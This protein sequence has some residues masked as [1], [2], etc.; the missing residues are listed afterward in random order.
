MLEV[1]RAESFRHREMDED[2]RVVVAALIAPGHLVQVGRPP[3][4]RSDPREG[5][6]Q[7]AGTPG[8]AAAVLA[9]DRTGRGPVA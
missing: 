9:A 1:L 7:T 3:L 8:A 6:P 2:S 5:A 4:Q